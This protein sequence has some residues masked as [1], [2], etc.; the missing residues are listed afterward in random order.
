MFARLRDAARAVD[1]RLAVLRLSSLEDARD[2]TPVNWLVRAAGFAF[3]A[4]GAVALG[5]A[6]VGLYAVKA[7]LV[8]RRTREI[9]VRMALGASPHGVIALVIK[10]GGALLA[11]GVAVGFLLALGTGYLVSSLLVG[12]KPLDPLVFTLATATLVLAV[13]TAAYVPAR[14]ATRIDPSVALRS[15]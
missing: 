10:D 3:G 7:C 8:A 1:P 6:V 2:S 15:E 11:A 12:V 14:R 4:L 9:G 13:W 5:M